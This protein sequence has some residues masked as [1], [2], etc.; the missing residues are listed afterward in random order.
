MSSEDY[1]LTKKQNKE[2]DNTL[3]HIFSREGVDRKTLD[4]V[5]ISLILYHHVNLS[6][7]KYICVVPSQDGS[8]SAVI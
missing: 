7:K 6:A 8:H 3:Q 1:F 4:E 2:I 5:F